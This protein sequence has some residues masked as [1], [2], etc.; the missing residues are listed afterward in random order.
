M[1]HLN[2]TLKVQYAEGKQEMGSYLV[3]KARHNLPNR[4]TT[5]DDVAYAL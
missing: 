1:I 4:I 5:V 2:Q 3:T